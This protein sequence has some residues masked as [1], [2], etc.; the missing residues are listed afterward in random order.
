MSNRLSESVMSILMSEIYELQL[1]ASDY[2]IEPLKLFPKTCEKRVIITDFIP[3]FFLT[4]F[5]NSKD[6][7]IQYSNV[8]NKAIHTLTVI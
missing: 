2:I 6:A 5:W 4:L 1:D 7:A 3:D 8:V